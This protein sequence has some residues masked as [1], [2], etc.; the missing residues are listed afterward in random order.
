MRV[1]ERVHT[2]HLVGGDNEA[3]GKVTCYLSDMEGAR[4][5]EKAGYINLV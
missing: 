3:V 1:I 4:V 5:N 2:R